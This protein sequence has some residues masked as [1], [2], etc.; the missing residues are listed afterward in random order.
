MFFFKRNFVDLKEII[1]QNYR[2]GCPEQLEI[3]NPYIIK[4]KTIL[5]LKPHARKVSDIVID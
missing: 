1:K 2:D 4:A 5:R 3:Y